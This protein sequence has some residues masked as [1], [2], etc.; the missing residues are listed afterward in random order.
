MMTQSNEIE[1]VAQTFKAL[2]DP[3]RLRI[4]TMLRGSKAPLCVT[5]IASRLGVTQP[6]VSQHLRVLR[7]AGIVSS[8]RAGRRVHYSV[9]VE[10]LRAHG[11]LFS[12]ALNLK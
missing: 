2:S 4:V 1:R 5:A 8:M 3:T 6:A 12:D 7:A 9:D 10:A 11:R